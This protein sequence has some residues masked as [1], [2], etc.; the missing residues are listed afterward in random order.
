MDVL[1]FG[2]YG[3]NLA[4]LLISVMLSIGGIVLGVGYA[5]ESKKF[6]EFGKEEIIQ[7]LINGALVGGLLMLFSSGGIVNG[8]MNSVVMQSGTSI[9]CDAFLSYNSA[10]CFA[11]NYLVGPNQFYSSEHRTIGYFLTS[12]RWLQG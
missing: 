2:E 6:K 12:W 3:L 10:L 4:V 8:F 7:S 9:S 11:Y 1:P 5:I